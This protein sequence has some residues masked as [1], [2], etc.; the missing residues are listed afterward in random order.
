[1]KRSILLFVSLLSG[2]CLFQATATY[3]QNAPITTAATVGGAVP[4]TVA[5]PITVTGF[6]NIG[7]ISLTID[8]NYSVLHFVNGVLNSQL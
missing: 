1:M 7:A 5:V 8:Y 3:A 6:N 2:L 4:G